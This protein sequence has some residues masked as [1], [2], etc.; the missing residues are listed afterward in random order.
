[1][2]KAEVIL[3]ALIRIGC[4]IVCFHFS[5]V[6]R[7][8]EMWRGFREETKELWLCR[9]SGQAW[10]SC[11]QAG[12]TAGKSSPSPLA[13]QGPRP[14]PHLSSMPGVT[15][16]LFPPS[17]CANKL[18]G[19]NFIFF[20]QRKK[21]QHNLKA[22]RLLKK[23]PYGLRQTEPRQGPLA[24]LASLCGEG[25]LPWWQWHLGVKLT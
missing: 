10:V 24:G 16:L 3:F 18:N 5:S 2:D 13:A 17:I 20:P 25:T 9:L 15:W 6:L 1:M 4:A 7:I 19:N 12:Y 23:G 21:W 22:G 8:L 14:S 11:G